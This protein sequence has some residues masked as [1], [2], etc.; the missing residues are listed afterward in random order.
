VVDNTVGGPRFL[1]KTPKNV[2][3]IPYLIR[4]FPD[5]FFVFLK[6]N[7]RDT[8]SSLIEGWLAR[9]GV[10]YR[11]PV[12]LSLD[13]YRGRFWSYVLPPGWRDK[14]NTTIAEV[15][16]LQYVACNETALADRGLVPADSFIEVGFE[17]LLARPAVVTNYL[18][19]R[20]ELGRSEAISSMA[21]DL[22][23]H[24]VGTISPPRPGK[25]RDRAADIERVA[26]TLAPTM[27]RLG[28]ELEAG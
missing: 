22:A 18:L 15:T 1:D 14:A 17:D 23:S 5:A 6:R 20:L 21:K 12:S 19:E 26:P 4:L 8:V 28:Y 11:L 27:H 3:K 16:A 9:R 7:G 24:Q 2:L 25:W 13:A 10:S